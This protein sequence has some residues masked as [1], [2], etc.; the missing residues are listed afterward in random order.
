[1]KQ[2]TISSCSQRGMSVFNFLIVMMVAGFFM[3]FAFKVVPYYAENMYVVEALK[4]VGESAKPVSEMNKREIK[5]IIQRHYMLNNVRAEGPNNID[6]DRSRDGLLVNIN[7]E[8]RVPFLEVLNLDLVMSFENQ[9][10]S[11]DVEAC[12]KPTKPV[13]KK[14]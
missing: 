14:K 13:V 3:M 6:V 12:C 9:L 8:V 11:S 4:T 2:K 10:D 7:Y 5:T 1:M